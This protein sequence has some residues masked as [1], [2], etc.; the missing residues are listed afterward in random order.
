MKQHLNH[1]HVSEWAVEE[2]QRFLFTRHHLGSI[3]VA[4]EQNLQA[5]AATLLRG[6]T[7]GAFHLCA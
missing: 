1:L 7:G 6:S 2:R 5:A 3:V 4:P